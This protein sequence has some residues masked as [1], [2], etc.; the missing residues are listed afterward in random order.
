[1][2][3]STT[4]KAPP[5]IFLTYD[6]AD[7]PFAAEVS[8]VLARLG[9]DVSSF[10]SIS[11]GEQYGEPIRKAIRSSDAVVLPLEPR[12]R[13]SELP[14]NVLF[15]LGAATAA[16]RAIYLV[17]R[18]A[19]VRLPFELP[20]LQILPMTRINEILLRYEADQDK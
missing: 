10:D 7:K 19:S 13:R 16:D 12:S 5:K 1:M 8:A 20:R 11:A 15:E 9:A 14:A 3:S 17:S 18:D 4:V 2:K 6:P